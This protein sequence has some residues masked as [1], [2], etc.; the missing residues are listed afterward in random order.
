MQ[1]W[2]KSK[3]K[4]LLIS[5]KFPKL[6]DSGN[7]LIKKF[8]W[9]VFLK[10]YLLLFWRLMGLVNSSRCNIPCDTIHSYLPPTTGYQ[11]SL[12]LLHI[13]VVKMHCFC[14]GLIWSIGLQP[15]HYTTRFASC[16]IKFQVHVWGK[17][18]EIS[19]EWEYVNAQL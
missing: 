1:Q 8:H 17:M 12:A 14:Y 9:K 19:N 15:I 18:L 6:K 2:G 3:F 16:F 7:V 5:L 10:M 4:I 11:F 13:W